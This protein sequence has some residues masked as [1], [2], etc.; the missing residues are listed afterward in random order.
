VQHNANDLYL[1][2]GTAYLQGKR[3]EYKNE[4]TKT[5]EVDLA[6]IH[7]QSATE[8]VIAEATFQWNFLN[9]F[10]VL[11]EL[12][13]W[14]DFYGQSTQFERDPELH[15][16]PIHK[17]QR[18]IEVTNAKDITDE[19][20]EIKDEWMQAE[21][22]SRHAYSVGD[23]NDNP[24]EQSGMIG[25]TTNYSTQTANIV[26]TLS[27]GLSQAQSQRDTA[28]RD[29]RTDFWDSQSHNGLTSAA[30]WAR[31][32]KANADLDFW[33]AMQQQRVVGYQAI[34]N[35]TLLPFTQSIVTS[36]TTS[37]NS[38]YDLHDDYLARTTL[39]NSAEAAY[40][41]SMEQAYVERETGLINVNSSNRLAKATITRNLSV[42]KAQLEDTYAR[43][44]AS[45]ALAYAN[46]IM[47]VPE[48]QRNDQ[49][50]RKAQ[51]KLNALHSKAFA[52]YY[53]ENAELDYDGFIGSLAADV[54]LLNGRANSE[55]DFVVARAAAY[56]SE[57]QGNVTG[58]A[59]LWAQ[60]FRDYEQSEYGTTASRANGVSNPSPWDTLNAA[61]L[62]AMAQNNNS[63]TR[64]DRSIDQA[65]AISQRESATAL[66]ELADRQQAVSISQAKSQADAMWNRD[67]AKEQALELFY[68]Y[69][70]SDVSQNAPY[71]ETGY[72]VTAPELNEPAAEEDEF[73]IDSVRHRYFQPTFYAADA[74]HQWGYSASQMIDMPGV[75]WSAGNTS[76]KMIDGRQD[77]KAFHVNVWWDFKNSLHWNQNNQWDVVSQIKLEKPLEFFDEAANWDRRLFFKDPTIRLTDQ[78][79]RDLYQS[80]SFWNTWEL[81]EQVTKISVDAIS[82]ESVSADNELLMFSDELPELPHQIAQEMTPS[83]T[84]PL[85]DG[86][87]AIE[88]DVRG[89]LTGFDSETGDFFAANGIQLSDQ[90]ELEADAREQQFEE[91]VDDVSPAPIPIEV[92]NDA[93]D[94]ANTESTEPQIPTPN[95]AVD[96]VVQANAEQNG[97]EVAAA[98]VEELDRTSE[99]EKEL[100]KKK[101]ELK[102]KI[103]AWFEDQQLP[104]GN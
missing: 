66:A 81:Q 8:V 84:E 80:S 32:Q 97:I 61:D 30:N 27:V 1:Q 67:M 5:F 3:H 83:E 21:I 47:E 34:H 15:A 23:G 22:D 6:E 41:A 11:P 38:L 70:G 99:L 20:Q 33:D 31:I 9:Q 46:V 82:Y 93:N 104:E 55:A 10:I 18:A 68:L 102:Q 7:R 14:N 45:A 43:G 40:S 29:A 44:S 49:Q 90:S 58:S 26:Y 59:A 98:N 63:A 96:Q 17:T 71:R 24:F 79:N 57:H 16:S 28:Y 103:D 42:N 2:V 85:T 51:Q 95:S 4:H 53:A 39:Q 37:L 92:E 75:L 60:S 87:K 52:T 64:Y 78:Q 19:Y 77:W 86:R 72:S 89:A 88:T 101:D 74:G 54:A 25:V 56:A 65:L 48:D 35:S 50:H 94:Q 62:N 100:L 36:A 76:F 13:T 12:A 91:M 69:V 73:R